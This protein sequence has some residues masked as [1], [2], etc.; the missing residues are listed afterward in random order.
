MK[1]VRY[2]YF[3]PW[4][5]I[6]AVGSYE[7]EFY[8]PANEIERRIWS[9]MG[10]LTF[11]VGLGAVLLVFVASKFLTDPIERLIAGVREVKRG[12]LDTQLA[13][14]TSDELGELASEF[15]RMAEMLRRNK[16]LEASLAQQN[17]MASLGVLSSEVAHEINNPWASS[18]ATPLTWKTR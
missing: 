5:W 4:N 16:E 11:V 9:S 1:I 13:V 3:A 17:K 10:L 6:V 7:N 2:Q 8:Q 12:R 14:T 15:N 18:W